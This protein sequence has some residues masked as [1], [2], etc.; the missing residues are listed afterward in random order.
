MTFRGKAEDRRNR[1]GANKL[2]LDDR[3]LTWGVCSQPW[4]HGDK[5]VL[6]ISRS[7]PDLAGATND[8]SCPSP[9]P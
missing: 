2:S 4:G 8:T 9:G 7:G 5:L 6:R 3:S 1:Q